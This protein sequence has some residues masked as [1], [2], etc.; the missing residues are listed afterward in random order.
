MKKSLLVLLAVCSFASSASADESAG[1]ATFTS[2]SNEVRALTNLSITENVM[3]K[4]RRDP[5]I[6]FIPRQGM[7]VTAF[8]SGEVVA[9]YAVRKDAVFRLMSKGGETS[10]SC[11]LAF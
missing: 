1:F 4:I 3:L 11:A 6:T 5:S 7:K 9:E 10:L 8:G 2:V